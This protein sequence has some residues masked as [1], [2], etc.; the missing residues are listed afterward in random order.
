MFFDELSEYKR[1]GILVEVYE[2]DRDL[3]KFYAGY[4]VACDEDFFIMSLISPRGRFDGFMLQEVRSIV[5][6]SHST[7]YLKQLI[8][9]KNHHNTEIKFQEF[10]GSDLLFGLLDYA[11]SNNR[12]VIIELL[13]N[14]KLT[15]GYIIKLDDEKCT[16]RQIAE[17]GDSDGDSTV[18]LDDITQVNCESESSVELEILARY[19][20]SI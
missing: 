1:D 19:Q 7:K 13:S 3:S 5:S 8:A 4:I 11:Q 2:D 10:D 18:L 17:D 15:S 9:I 12:I 20:N 14:S 16:V 6:I